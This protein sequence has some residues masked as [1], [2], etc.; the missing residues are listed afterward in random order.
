MRIILFVAASLSAT[1]LAHARNCSEPSSPYCVNAYGA[2][3]SRSE[4]ESCKSELESFKSETL[5]Y[6]GCLKKKSQE[7]IDEH[8]SAV[9][10]FNMRVR[11]TD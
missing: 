9:D 3:K 7:A 2:F 8:S 11:K 6:L 5:D 1:A 10:N 4:Y